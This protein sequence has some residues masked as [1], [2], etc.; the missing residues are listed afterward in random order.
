VQ[1]PKARRQKNS[2]TQENTDGKI[3]TRES[4]NMYVSSIDHEFQADLQN[5]RVVAKYYDRITLARLTE[6]LDLPPLTTERT[7]CKLVTDKIIYA[8]IDRS[9]G[10]VT[11]KPKSN[12]ADILNAWTADIDKMLGLVEKTSHLVSKVS[13]FFFYGMT[14]LMSRSTLCMRLPRERKS[15]LRVWFRG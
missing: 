6:L 2:R 13:F 7:L 1:T 12:T 3:F 14:E 15:R 8:R 4:S 9:S 5:I 10:I 11:F